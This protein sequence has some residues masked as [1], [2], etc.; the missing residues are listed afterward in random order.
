[1]SKRRDYAAILDIDGTL[2]KPGFDSSGKIAVLQDLEPYP[3]VLNTDWAQYAALA[4]CTGRWKKWSEIT[5]QWLLKAGIP[6]AKADLHF[7]EYHTEITP[8]TKAH[9]DYVKRKSFK[10]V[11]LIA[12]FHLY[13][14]DVDLYEDDW[15]VISTVALLL[16]LN[17]TH[18]YID[19][20]RVRWHLKRYTVRENGSLYSVDSADWVD[21]K[22]G[23]FPRNGE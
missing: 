17:P 4:C 14:Y 15:Y 8:P 6:V 12:N 20:R 7:V 9:E 3:W 13:G 23:R 5:H 16:G 2:C 10:L 21:L 22:K 1:M 19:I 18:A 11:E